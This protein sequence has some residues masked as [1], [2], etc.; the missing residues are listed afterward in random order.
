M[1]WLLCLDHILS[2]KI[3]L[4]GTLGNKEEDV[5]HWGSIKESDLENI[6]EFNGI[7]SAY[8]FSLVIC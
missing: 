5:Q 1:K 7:H 2:M 3:H 6:W 8:M 4:N